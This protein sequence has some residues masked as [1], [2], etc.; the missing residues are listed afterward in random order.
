MSNVQVKNNPTGTM[1]SRAAKRSRYEKLETAF[2]QVKVNTNNPDIHLGDTAIFGQIPMKGLIEAR[3]KTNAGTPNK[4]ELLMGSDLTDSP[5]T[6]TVGADTTVID[7]VVSYIK[8]TGHIGTGN[9]ENGANGFLLAVTVNP[10]TP[11]VVSKSVTPGGA[12][13]TTAAVSSTVTSQGGASTVTF[14]YGTTTGYG[15]VVP[16]TT[17]GSIAPGV[18]GNTTATLSLTGL[19]ASTVYHYRVNI[20][21]ASGTVHSTDGTFTTHAAT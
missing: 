15:T 12:P 4:L 9:A 14:E 3:L 16:F 18:T 10:N 8:G 20:T 7:Y 2:G 17:N 1:G 21:N 13:G 5:V 6:W 11:V 19:T